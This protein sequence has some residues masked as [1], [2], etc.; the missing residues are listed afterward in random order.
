MVLEAA[1]VG[2]WYVVGSDDCSLSGG[3]MIHKALFKQGKCLRRRVD[4]R[5]VMKDDGI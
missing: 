4:D 1:M 5:E 2:S 3:I